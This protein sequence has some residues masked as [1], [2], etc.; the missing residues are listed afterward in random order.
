MNLSFYLQ[1][2][3]M[4]IIPLIAVIVPVLVGQRIGIRHSQIKPDIQHS[5]IESVVSA[6]FGLLAF[7]LA[8][9]F[10]IAAN[11]YDARKEMLIEEITQIR[12]AYIR[13]GL[14]P[15]PYNA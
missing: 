11:R 12:T 2:G 10:Q 3:S 5:S 13:A 6:A 15:E 8:F 7:M 1:V 9:T 4:F 14:L